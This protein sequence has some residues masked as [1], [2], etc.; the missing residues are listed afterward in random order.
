MKI[1]KLKPNWACIDCRKDTLANDEHYQLSDHTWRRANP[2]IIGVLCLDCVERRLGR[3]LHA[4]DFTP[5]AIN[6]THALRCPPL[7]QRLTRAPLPVNARRR[8]GWALRAIS[9]RP[10][11]SLGRASEALLPF[12]EEDGRVPLD[13][14]VKVMRQHTFVDRRS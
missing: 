13:V 12:R 8:K 11:T 2:L 9:Q 14:V 6:A 1:A 4:G 5:A 10:K 3:P 7:A